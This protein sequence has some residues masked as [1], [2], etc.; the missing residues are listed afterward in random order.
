MYYGFFFSLNLLVTSSEYRF[1]LAYEICEQ[2]LYSV[3]GKF[4]FRRYFPCPLPIL[5]NK[6]DKCIVWRYKDEW[7]LELSMANFPLY[8]GMMS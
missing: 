6:I 1:V 7:G 4:P 2:N 8:D 3:H 5:E